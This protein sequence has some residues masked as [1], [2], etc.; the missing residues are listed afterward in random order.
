MNEEQRRERQKN[1]YLVPE[2]RERDEKHQGETG[3]KM[4]LREEL[5]SPGRNGGKGSMSR[6]SGNMAH[7]EMGSN[8]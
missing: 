1:P 5:D 6:G 7:D 8:K 2:M 3:L 4:A